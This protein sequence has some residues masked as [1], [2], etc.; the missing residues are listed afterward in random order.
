MK[1]MAATC[2][3]LLAL[4]A[5]GTKRGYVEKGN[6]LFQKGKYEDA[7][8]NYRKA[9]QKDSK[10]GDA[11]YRLGLDA[12]KLG[13]VPDAYEALYRAS[14]LLPNNLE[15]KGQFA[16]FCL[17]NYLKDP[18]RPQKLYQQIQQV[19][20]DF[21]ARNPNS[22]EGLRLKGYLAY[23]DRKPQEAIA[24]FRKA[25]Q[26]QPDS[27]PVITALVE[28]LTA[29]GQTQEAEKIA[30][31]LLA[32][33]KDYGPLYDALAR[34]YS[35][36]NRPADAEKAL[37]SKAD[38]NPRNPEYIVELA[39]H[40][41][42][43]GNT[44][45]MKNTLQRMLNDPKN[46][47]NA[48]FR[49]GDFYVQQ[50]KYEDA[51]RY[52]QEGAQAYPNQKVAY[53]KRALAALLVDA[54]Y[55]DAKR[56]DD[57]ILRNDPKDEVSLRIKADLLINAGGV[58]NANA[59]LPILQH[60]LD[61]HPNDDNPSLRFQMGRAY[62]LKENLDSARAQF[63]AAIRMRNDYV[64]ARYELAEISLLQQRSPEA[65]EQA[66]AILALTPSDR[67]ARLLY[68]RSLLASGDAARA[69]TELAQLLKDSPK[70]L[71]TRLALGS[72]AIQ[73]RKYSEAIETLNG[74]KDSGDPR[75]FAGLVDAYARAEQVDKA[76]EVAN[77]GLKRLP[78]SIL[79]RQQLAI[80]LAMT[81]RF[82]PSISE[83]QKLIAANPKSLENY[84]R[85]GAIY[86]VK[87]D[88]TDAIRLF[89]QAHDLAPTDLGPALTL[90]EGLARA[91]RRSEATAVYQTIL[92]THPNDATALN[93]TAYFLCDSGG[94]LDEALKLAQTAVQKAP[95]QPAFADT[96]GYVYLKRGMRTAA[97][98]TFSG[99]VKNHPHYATYRYHLG[100]AFYETGD[101][102]RAK[103]E[104][105]DALAEHPSRKD[106]VRINELL[107][108]AG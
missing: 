53:Q 18:A 15:V 35:N 55:D 47:P 72:L 75:A 89:Q 69:R 54:K 68:A 93:N 81:G 1:K 39:T 82:D 21:L 4:T 31:N 40:Y 57:E 12:V 79:I 19:S 36:T 9:I 76:V 42:L 46:F 24:Y 84:V 86:D 62:R 34:I 83:F 38:N 103:K 90:A 99:L 58:E 104:L 74:I 2:L 77:D 66:T 88:Y 87:G 50:K 70:D 41:A 61:A 25:V 30:L 20:S 8:I 22:F 73:Q 102:T 6:A 56:L 48:Q 32:R 37:R 95:D 3:V 101:K 108:R 92:K 71:E 67:R 52:Y 100:L 16:D 59:A 7:A 85:L 91:G 60:E 17:E 26:I 78:N 98:Q 45:E 11:Y 49:V 5:C 106:A 64:A 94:N 44:A 43:A 96:L 51:V 27:A 29:S 80:S 23:A 97:I 10:Y 65:L 107:A 28:T 13:N 105:R 14:Q 63:A 33:H